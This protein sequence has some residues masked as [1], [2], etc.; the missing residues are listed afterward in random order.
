MKKKKQKWLEVDRIYE[1]TYSRN[2]LPILAKGFQPKLM[3]SQAGAWERRKKFYK[4]S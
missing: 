4:L 3:H 2:N 1:P